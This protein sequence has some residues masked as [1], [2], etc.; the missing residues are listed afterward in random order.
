M[1]IIKSFSAVIVGFIALNSVQAGSVESPQLTI[2]AGIT[3]LNRNLIQQPFNTTGTR[4]DGTA[5]SSSVQIIPQMSLTYP[6]NNKDELKFQVLPFS[7]STTLDKSNSNL[8]YNGVSFDASKPTTLDYKF[9]GYRGTWRR[10]VFENKNHQLQLGGTLNIRDA[11]IEVSQVGKKSQDDDIGV[12]PLLHIAS[13][14]RF[15]DTQK[16]TTEIDGSWA[17]Q[18][19]VVD[20]TIQYV[21]K[22]DANID[23]LVGY[24]YFSGGVSMDTSKNS[25]YNSA[26]FQSLL[27]G[28]SFKF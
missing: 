10:T 5:N 7:Y 20:A 26:A 8:N 4:F 1:K 21:H 17:K 2:Q 19:Y 18:G 14:H 11:K 27:L 13:Q 23:A 12:V 3:S 24:R 6:L 28:G 9:N 15:N 16:I 25:L 22:L